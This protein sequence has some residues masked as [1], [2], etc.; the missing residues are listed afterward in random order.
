MV[1]SGLAVGQRAD[2]TSRRTDGQ[3]VCRQ[4]ARDDGTRTDDGVL[5]D[6]DPGADDDAATKPNVV[7][8]VDRLSPLPLFAAGT[9][10]NRMRCRQQLHVRTYLHVVADVDGRYVEDD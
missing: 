2:H 6:R 8:E 9:W 7:T 5:A 1:R 4:V 10:L 3:H